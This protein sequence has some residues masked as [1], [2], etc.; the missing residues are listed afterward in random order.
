MVI[1]T[2]LNHLA[3]ERGLAK[4]SLA[5]YRRDLTRLAAFLESRS[6]DVLAVE[7]GDLDQFVLEL[8]TG[9]PAHP[10]LSAAST[11]RTIAAVRGLY[12]FA[13]TEGLLTTDPAEALHRPQVAQR[14]P[15]ALS[16]QQVS[17]LLDAVETD[18]PVGMR[19]KAF[20]ELL[21]GTGSRVSEAVGLDIDD[22]GGDEGIDA[23]RLLGKGDKERIV[24][25]GSYAA[26]ALD[27]Y[28]V[29][30][31]PALASAGRGT[32]AV[33]LNTRGNRLSRQSGWA[34]IQAA[35]GRAFPDDEVHL[36]P[37]VLRHSFATHLLQGGA[38]IRV[39]QELLGHASVTTTQLYTKVT[40]EHLR[41][42]YITAHPRAR[43]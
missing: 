37:H 27:Q 1:Q 29:R 8:R 13:V 17:Q 43:G 33:F 24:P 38:D 15:K 22:L 36:S 32:P 25:V 28:L 35:A 4:N 5:A 7:P 20:L 34:I 9:T 18:T 30:A 26:S 39:V 12:R 14:L 21:Y 42:V 6:I 11:A 19:D 23:V 10:P 2:Y 31:R 40:P 41:E 16:T 3:V